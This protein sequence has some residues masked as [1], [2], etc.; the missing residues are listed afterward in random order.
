MKI[1]LER[2][3]L[4]KIDM[5]FMRLNN[6]PLPVP[7]DIDDRYL[8]LHECAPYAIVAHDALLD[9]YF[10]YANQTALTCFKYSRE[11]FLQ[12]RSRFSAIY[13]E[14]AERQ[15]LLDDVHHNGI[16]YDYSGIRI[17]KMKMPFTIYDGIV[18]QLTDERYGSHENTWGQ[19]ACFYYQLNDKVSV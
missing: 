4:K 2:D 8:W 19:A 5:C 7:D 11:E 9:P 10:I 17:D 12:M 1:F 6:S 15:R 16:V 14:R 3:L 18:W 13:G